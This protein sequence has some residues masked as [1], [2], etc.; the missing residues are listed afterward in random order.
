MLHPIK[1][2]QSNYIN[3]VYEKIYN[4]KFSL[5]IN[6]TFTDANLLIVI[7]IFHVLMGCMLIRIFFNTVVNS[8]SRNNST[9]VVQNHVLVN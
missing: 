3:Y 6:N 8:D 4:S 5:F 7:N 9:S 1:I 2:I